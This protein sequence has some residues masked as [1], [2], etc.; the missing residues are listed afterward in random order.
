MSKDT[1][2]IT[3][4]IASVLAEEHCSYFF[5]APSAA[6]GLFT[7]RLYRSLGLSSHLGW[8]RLLLDRYQDLVETPH[9]QSQRTSGDGQRPSLDDEDAFE[10]E[11]FHNPDT[12]YHAH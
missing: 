6:K 5:E 10:H 12:P 3:D 2:I 9:L 1:Y 7:Q 4:L 8:A 11:M